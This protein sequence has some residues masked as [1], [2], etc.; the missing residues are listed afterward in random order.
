MRLQKAAC[1]LA[2]LLLV[3]AS[4][5]GCRLRTAPGEAVRSATGDL[6]LASLVAVD[7]N[8]DYGVPVL[9]GP[10]IASFP[11][12]DVQLWVVNKW[13]GLQSGAHV[14]SVRILGPGGS[15][16]L[17]EEVT[18]FEWTGAHFNVTT[19]KFFELKGLKPGHYLVAVALD[20][21]EIQR[22]GIRVVAMD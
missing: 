5:A 12:G 15:T 11:A 1:G 4:V 13:G 18:E 9:V 16:V 2:V 7:L 22:Y 14:D 19:A 8:A 20:G 3:W 6:Y 17:G 10:N 21:S